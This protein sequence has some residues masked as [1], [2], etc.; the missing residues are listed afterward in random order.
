MKEQL[1]EYLPA[2]IQILTPLLLAILTWAAAEAVRLIR[3]KTQAGA[4]QDALLRLVDAVNTV[5]SEMAQTIVDDL[6]AAA[7]DGNLSEAD[8][9]MIRAKARERLLAY[10]GRGAEEQMRSL[11]GSDAFE[12]M[13]RAKF[14]QA[15]RL[16][17]S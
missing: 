1:A 11:F 4:A 10:L 16:M 3:S 15:V 8:I 14:E 2:L 5:S 13:I 6:K 7:A 12:T 17:K 9:A